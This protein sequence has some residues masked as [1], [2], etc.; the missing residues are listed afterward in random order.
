M[1][2]RS[3]TS[4][5][6]HTGTELFGLAPTKFFIRSGRYYCTMLGPGEHHTPLQLLVTHSFDNMYCGF[7]GVKNIVFSVAYIRELTYEHLPLF[8]LKY[9]RLFIIP[10]V[11]LSSSSPT[12]LS[13]TNILFGSLP[14]L[15]HIHLLLGFTLTRVV[16]HEEYFQI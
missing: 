2:I 13:T 1:P 16:I 8:Y 12:F 14:R 15:C 11:K 10:G 5:P 9:R 7:V 6:P 3:M 4:L